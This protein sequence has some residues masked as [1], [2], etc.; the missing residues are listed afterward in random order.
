MLGEEREVAA[1]VRV[2]LQVRE[3]APGG[4]GAAQQEQVPLAVGEVEQQG[5][6]MPILAAGIT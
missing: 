4:R 2:G 1:V 6:H 3:A 5:A